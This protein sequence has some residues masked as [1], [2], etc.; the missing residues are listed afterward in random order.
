[1]PFRVAVL[2]ETR[3][4]ERRRAM[5]P[6]VGPQLEKLGAEIVYD[7]GPGEA[8]GADVVLGVQPPT[9]EVARALKPGAVLVSFLYAEQSPELVTTLKERGVI[10]LAME[11][12]PRISRA[13][14][15]D[16]LSSQAALAG[17]YA[18]VLGAT[19]LE[20]VLPRMTTAAG[21]IRPA[22][23]LV[24][25]LGVAGLQAIATLRRLGAVIEAYDVR[26]ETKE[27]AE[28]LGAKFVS[29][30]VDA[31]GAGGYARELTAEERAKIAAVVT[32]HIQSADLVITA[33]SVPGRKAPVLITAE[34]VAGMKAGAV[35]V[36]LGAESG[37]NCALSRP[38]ETV[39]AQG[40]GGEVAIEAPLNLTSRLAEPAS[41]LY[42]KNVANLLKLV[43]ADGAVKLDW[44]D[45][46]LSGAAVLKG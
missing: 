32:S 44:T 21:V 4:D 28:S 17:Y 6:A 25:G 38:G 31:R 24:M 26:P 43:I 36:D 40:K 3:A 41:E 12:V 19:R 1:M 15:M 20:R 5:V 35:I 29:T 42:A 37:G 30:G 23:A 39:R 18:A 45:E 7:A 34:Q 13:Q 16:A 14:A 22:T 10:A 8:A 27:E 46:I 9:L 2:K 33:A 11:R